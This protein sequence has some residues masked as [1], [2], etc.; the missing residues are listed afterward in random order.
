MSDEQPSPSERLETERIIAARPAAIFDVLTDPQG[1]VDVD[2]SGMLQSAT[3][4]RVTAVGDA[5]VV[6]MDREALG[7]IPEMGEYD[8]TVTITELEPERSIAW[9]IL[10]R[11]RPQIGHTYGYRLEAIEP[12]EDG[13]PRTRVTSVYDW[14]DAAPQ[15]KPI[16]PVISA[17]HLKATLGILAREVARRAR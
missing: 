16:F 14:S 10:G 1:H 6:H 5:F 3:G 17:Q 7:D 9:T 11:I 4:E 13:S 2:S 8:V 12:A 15:W